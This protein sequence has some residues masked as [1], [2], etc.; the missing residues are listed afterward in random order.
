VA[1]PRAAA[2]IDGEGGRH[3]LEGAPPAGFAAAL[4]EALEPERGAVVGAAGRAL[5]ESEYSIEALARRL[6]A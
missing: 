3:Y 6:A 1:T 5:A 2:G 4:L